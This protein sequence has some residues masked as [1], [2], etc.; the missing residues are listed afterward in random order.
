MCSIP[1]Q[2]INNQNPSRINQL[3][4][5]LPPAQEQ[6]KPNVIQKS[7]KRLMDKYRGLH[8]ILNT[9]VIKK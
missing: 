6:A 2:D 9:V 5:K 1:C 7:W 8:S 4:V 3:S